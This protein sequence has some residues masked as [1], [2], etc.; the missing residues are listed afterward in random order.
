MAICLVEQADRSTDSLLG[1]VLVI[2]SAIKLGA[3]QN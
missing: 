2:Y 1:S 3:N